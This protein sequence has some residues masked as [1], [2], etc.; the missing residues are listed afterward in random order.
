MLRAVKSRAFQRKARRKFFK[1]YFLPLTAETFSDINNFNNQYST[2][3]NKS[4]DSLKK[5]NKIFSAFKVFFLF[6]EDG[7]IEY[8]LPPIVFNLCIRWRT[9][10]VSFICRLF[11]SADNF[12]EKISGIF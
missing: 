5:P 8:C 9:W 6:D 10:L 1:Q 12:P 7:D 3:G 2:Y 4:T 11:D